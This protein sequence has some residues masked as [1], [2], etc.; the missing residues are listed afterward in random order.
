[1][2]KGVIYSTEEERKIAQKDNKK[3]YV[4]RHP[5]KRKAS[6]KKYDDAHKEEARLYQKEHYKT[7]K[8]R[9]D[10]LRKQLYA[11]RFNTL[12]EM[13]GDV[14]ACCGYSDKRFLCLDHIKGQRGRKREEPQA[15]YKRAI[16]KYQPKEFRVLCHNCNH[17]TRFG[18]MCPHQLD[19]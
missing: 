1:M 4:E 5:E 3:R 10:E 16:S 14:C 18:D 13:Y 19:K 7:Y 17:A 6:V 11:E 2:F 15:A 9:K 8:S 12:L